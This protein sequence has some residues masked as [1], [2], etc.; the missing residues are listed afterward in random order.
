VA[1]PDEPTL[2]E[3]LEEFNGS[4]LHPLVQ[5]LN[6]GDLTPN[7]RSELAATHAELGVRLAQLRAKSDA[8]HWAVRQ[9]TSTMLVNA[10]RVYAETK[11]QL[12]DS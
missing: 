10:E 1:H 2:D 7:E 4:L 11:A 6:R 12:L 9:R 5:Q 3:Q 8:S